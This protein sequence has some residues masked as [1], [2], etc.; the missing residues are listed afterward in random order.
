M[1]NK[2]NSKT[3]LLD[4]LETRVFHIILIEMMNAFKKKIV[5]IYEVNEQ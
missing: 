2:K 4:D 3:D 5:V 1:Q